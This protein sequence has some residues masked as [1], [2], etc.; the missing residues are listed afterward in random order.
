MKEWNGSGGIGSRW[1]SG[2]SIEEPASKTQEDKAKTKILSVGPPTPAAMRMCCSQLE[3]VPH[4]SVECLLVYST[5]CQRPAWWC[6]LLTPALGRWRQSV[7][8]SLKTFWSTVNSRSARAKSEDLS[9][10]KNKNKARNMAQWLG[11]SRSGRGPEFDFQ[12]L[13]AV[14]Q[15]QGIQCP[16]SMGTECYAHMYMH[17]YN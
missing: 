9:Q 2:I 11:G 14:T 12:Y 3:C 16:V 6:T 7:S 8:V 1:S 17:T 5:F 4:G 13:R 10:N 15:V